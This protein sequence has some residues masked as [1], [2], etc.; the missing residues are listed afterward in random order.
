MNKR[1]NKVRF[2][3]VVFENEPTKVKVFLNVD[4]YAD[5]LKDVTG[6][7]YSHEKL[8]GLTEKYTKLTSKMFAEYINSLTEL[9]LSKDEQQKV[10][11]KEIEKYA[12]LITD[13]RKEVC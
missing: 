12:G 3:K 13:T 4:Y 5:G 6:R 8:L 1:N 11:E 7:D 10:I 9:G 2:I